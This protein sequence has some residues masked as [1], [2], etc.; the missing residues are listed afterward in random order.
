MQNSW[1]STPVELDIL[2]DASIEHKWLLAAQLIGMD[3][4]KLTSQVGH[5]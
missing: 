5:A 2:F 3:Y 1:F 4:N